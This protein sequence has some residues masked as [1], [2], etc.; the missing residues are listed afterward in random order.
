MRCGREARRDPAKF[1]AQHPVLFWA[2]LAATVAT[3][4]HFARRARRAGGVRRWVWVALAAQQGVQA[5][6]MVRVLTRAKA[7]PA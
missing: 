3:A 7:T 5:A 1:L 2:A 6:G 4:L